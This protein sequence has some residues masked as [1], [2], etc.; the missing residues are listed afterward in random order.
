MNLRSRSAISI[1]SCYLNSATPEISKRV[2]KR[3]ADVLVRL[4]STVSLYT[5]VIYCSGK[6]GCGANIQACV[7]SDYF[8]L[9]SSH[10]NK[11]VIFE[12]NRLYIG[13]SLKFIHVTLYLDP[14]LSTDNMSDEAV[15]FLLT[16][17]FPV[18]FWS[19]LLPRIISCTITDIEEL[20][21]SRQRKNEH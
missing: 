12:S 5:S 21:I 1:P 14:S 6:V 4:L 7:A 2:N 16:R 8:C 13:T 17:K 3:V 18:K 10:A 9:V 15:N 20:V 11:V 19:S